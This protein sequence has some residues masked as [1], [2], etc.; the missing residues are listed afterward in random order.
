[1][2]KDGFHSIRGLMLGAL[3]ASV[4]LCAIASPVT[5]DVDFSWA[6]N[7][8]TGTITSDDS[9]SG[10]DLFD[11]VA[12]W[13][14]TV[15]NG[16][17]SGTS[18]S[19]EDGSSMVIHQHN[20]F[21]LPADVPI[22]YSDAEALYLDLRGIQFNSFFRNRE[23]RLAGGSGDDPFRISAWDDDLLGG[24]G[25]HL[26]FT[27]PEQPLGSSHEYVRFASDQQKLTIGRV[28]V[29]EPSTWALMLVA[30]CGTASVVRRR[31]AIV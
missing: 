29:P 9:Y 18:N 31:R 13:S 23:F 14:L 6:S 25:I 8:L 10:G 11:H 12:G 27:D 3:L 26:V 19:W 1:M 7:H 2:R 20:G 24:G 5:F 28:A 4:P 21:G 22:L 15:A 30:L 16:T 17:Y